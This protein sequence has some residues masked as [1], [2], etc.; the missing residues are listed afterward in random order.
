MKGKLGGILVILLG[1]ILIAA[2]LVLK[3]VVLPTMAVWP[4]DVDSTRVYD[5]TLVTTLN[6][7]LVTA[8]ALDPSGQ[9]A[10]A[11][12]ATMTPEQVQQF[13][14]LKDIPVT[15]DRHVTTEA[16]AGNEALVKEEATMYGRNPDGSKGDPIAGMATVDYYTI[17]RTTTEFAETEAFAGVAGNDLVEERDGLVIGFPIGTEAITYDGW[18]DDCQ[19]KVDVEFVAVEEHEGISTYRFH[20]ASTEPVP[21]ED[22]SLF[23]SGG[24]PLPDALPKAL[25]AGMAPYL[26]LP[27]ALVQGLAMM[28]P[29]LP[30]QVELPYSYTW[31]T[32]YWVEPTTGVLIDYTKSEQRYLDVPALLET[33]GAPM[34]G[35]QPIPVFDLNYAATDQSIA[36]AKA[37]AKTPKMLL[38]LF[39]WLPWVIVGLGGLVTIG[40]AFMLVRKPKKAVAAS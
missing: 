38:D 18:C 20:S 37:D 23:M 30:D 13:L 17:D 25:L 3:L 34:P 31:D 2:G 21:I 39:E 33:L 15:V 7:M 14:F 11:Q 35:V 40:G 9:A 1:Q 5:G 12:L 24:G 22:P 36:D 8:L 19:D 10:A 6:P 29:M 16:V 4:D 27:D 32:E 26:G 28:L